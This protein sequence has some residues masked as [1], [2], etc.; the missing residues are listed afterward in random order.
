MNG[1]ENDSLIYSFA[2][3]SMPP[4]PLNWSVLGINLAHRRP[5]LGNGSIRKGCDD[6]EPL[7]KAA[8][9]SS[10]SVFLSFVSSALTLS[11]SLK[12]SRVMI[13]SKG[14]C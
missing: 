12:C 4:L 3:A 11:V 6:P 9:Y 5:S 8:L 14:I 2:L 13:R 7:M 10:G 1:I